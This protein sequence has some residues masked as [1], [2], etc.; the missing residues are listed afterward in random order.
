LNSFQRSAF[1]FRG[2]ARQD[3]TATAAAVPKFE[4]NRKQ[5]TALWQSRLGMNLSRKHPIPSRDRQGA[6]KLIAKSLS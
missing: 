6:V 1:S 5:Q 3:R 2:T 4:A